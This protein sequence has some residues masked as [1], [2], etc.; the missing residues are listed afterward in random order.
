VPTP[1][2][3]TNPADPADPAH[4]AAGYAIASTA[5]DPIET[6]APPDRRPHQTPADRHSTPQPTQERKNP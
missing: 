2:P 6:S 1:K 3:G 4:R 5:A